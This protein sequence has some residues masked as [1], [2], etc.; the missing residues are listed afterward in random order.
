MLYALVYLS[1]SRSRFSKHE[2][3]DI[4]A[5]S[6]RNNT[7]NGVTGMLLYRDGN[8]MQVLEGD[9]SVVRGLYDRIEQDPRHH[10]IITVW[11]AEEQHRQF[12]D[13]SM[14]FHNL[15]DVETSTPGFSRF[16]N[17]P[18]TADVFGS[19]PTLVQQLLLVFK[20]Q[21]ATRRRPS[22]TAAGSRPEPTYPGAVGAGPR[23][24]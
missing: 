9:K 10:G 15:A 21:Y 13:W 24:G 2:L 12:P 7:A 19:Q 11:E 6:R 17:I 16:L 4:L 14:A 20:D 22:Q 23:G 8:L 5:V 18:L 3:D 1:S